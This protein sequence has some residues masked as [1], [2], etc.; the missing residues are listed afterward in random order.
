MSNNE[1]FVIKEKESIYLFLKQ[2]RTIGEHN[3]S[4]AENKR[5]DADS[6]YFQGR[7]HAYLQCAEGMRAFFNLYGE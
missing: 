5:N 7:G 3:L 1:E 4:K 2:M 6:A